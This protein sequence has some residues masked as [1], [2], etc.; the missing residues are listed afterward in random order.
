MPVVGRRFGGLELSR[1]ETLGVSIFTT[2][3]ECL[4]R[5][6]V[7]D[8]PSSKSGFYPFIKIKF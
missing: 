3:N 8:S 4:V 1:D 6:F 5:Y 7:G 2:K